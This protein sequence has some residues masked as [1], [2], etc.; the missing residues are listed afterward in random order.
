MGMPSALLWDRTC[1]LRSADISSR[2]VQTRIC[3]TFY[4]HQAACDGA[5]R[6]S[7]PKSNYLTQGRA[8]KS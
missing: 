6:Y 2:D 3:W 5:R 4:F 7:G 8:G 1:V